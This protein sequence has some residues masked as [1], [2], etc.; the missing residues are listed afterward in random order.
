[1]STKKQSIFSQSKKLPRLFQTPVAVSDQTAL[2]GPSSAKVQLIRTRSP[3]EQEKAKKM[4]EEAK[5]NKK[6]ANDSNKNNTKTTRTPV[7]DKDR[8]AEGQAELEAIKKYAS[9]YVGSPGFLERFYSRYYELPSEY[10]EY[11]WSYRINPN[12]IN[13]VKLKLWKGDGYSFADAGSNTINMTEIGMGSGW[14][15]RH[16]GRRSM[17]HEMG[18]LI[19]DNVVN[20][21]RTDKNGKKEKMQYS[22]LYNKQLLT[23]DEG[24]RILKAGIRSNNYLTAKEQD[25]L[26]SKYKDKYHDGFDIEP[27]ADLFQMRYLLDKLD[28]YDSTKKN[29]KFTKEIL[30]EFRRKTNNG[31]GLGKVPYHMAIKRILQQHSDEEIIDMMNTIAKLDSRQQLKNKLRPDPSQAYYAKRGTRLIKKPKHK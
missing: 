11:S 4:A 31:E 20:V 27:Y 19:D 1:M 29:N 2:V 3:Q 8:I 13:K 28:L 26:Y 30:Q 6:A 14:W 22:T 15:P 17:T 5:K 12:K 25:E 9:K 10:P 24:R 21:F 23:G 18:H 16:P 7:T